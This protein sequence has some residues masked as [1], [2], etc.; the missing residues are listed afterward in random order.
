MCGSSGMRDRAAA[1]GADAPTSSA[2]ELGSQIG[3]MASGMNRPGTRRTTRRCAS[4]CTPARMASARSLSLRLAEHA[5][6]EPG[7]GRE[8]HRRQHAVAVH[9]AHALVDVVRAGRI[10][11]NP[12][13]V[14]APLLLGPA[15]DRV[16]AHR[17]DLL[18]LEHPL[19][20]AVVA[21]HDVGHP[22]GVLGRHV[23]LEHVG[24]FDDVVVDADQDQVVELHGSSRECGETSRYPGATVDPSPVPDRPIS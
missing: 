19:L 20:D 2:I 3:G 6:R 8:A 11:A 24:R 1:L 10:S 4:R 18:A 9:V 12:S 21:H 16:Q 7:E 15:D 14:E 22:V 17:A 13:R 23:A 5:G